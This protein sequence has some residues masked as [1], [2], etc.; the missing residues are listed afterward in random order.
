MVHQLHDGV[1]LYPE[2][3]SAC[4]SD[5]LRQALVV[6]SP[7]R[8]VA[9]LDLQDGTTVRDCSTRESV[10][11]RLTSTI[12]NIAMLHMDMARCAKLV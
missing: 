5:Q 12:Q 8:G 3:H 9:V 11:L 7:P 2:L 1:E 10:G 4:E 6:N